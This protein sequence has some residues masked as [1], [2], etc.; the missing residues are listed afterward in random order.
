MAAAGLRRQLWVGWNEVGCSL[1]GCGCGGDGGWGLPDAFVPIK[2]L[3][4]SRLPL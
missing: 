3:A 4:Y 1:R 2:Y